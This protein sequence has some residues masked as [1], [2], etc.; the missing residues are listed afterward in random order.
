MRTRKPRRDGVSAVKNP[1]LRNDSVVD[2][3]GGVVG[4]VDGG[5]G[6]SGEEILEEMD[7]EEIVEEVYESEGGGEEV[8]VD[9]NLGE[10]LKEEGVGVGRRGWKE[11]E[12]RAIA[13][14][15]IVMDS[16]ELNL[17]RERERETVVGL[18]VRKMSEEE[19]SKRA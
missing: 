5:A 8:M 1:A 4:E 7:F 14:H 12:V 3:G 6:E 18:V 13:I 17:E 19:K 9:W 15:G 11:L 16:E 10:G 2:Y